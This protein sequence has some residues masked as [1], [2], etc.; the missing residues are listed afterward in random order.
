MK[1]LV[2]LA[3][4]IIPLCVVAQKETY[5]MLTLNDPAGFSREQTT[6]HLKFLKKDADRYCQIAIF[7][8]RTATGNPVEEFS[9]EWDDLVKKY[10]NVGVPD[11]KDVEGPAD[12]WTV[13]SAVA[14]AR[15]SNGDFASMLL[16]IVGHGRVTSIR[17]DVNTEAFNGDVENFISGIAPES[18]IADELMS[19]GVISQQPIVHVQA[20]NTTES[21]FK[22]QNL[23]SGVWRGLGT[24][25]T[26]SGVTNAAGTGYASF[27][28]GTELGIKQIAFFDDGTYCNILPSGGLIDYRD[29]RAKEPNYWGT[30]KL[31]NGKGSIKWDAFA[32]ADQFSIENGV[33]I[34]ARTEFRKLKSVDNWTFSGIFTAETNPSAYNGSEPTISFNSDG[35]FDDHGAIY[36][37]RHVKG[38]NEDMQDKMT[39]SGVYEVMNYTIT[40]RYDDGRL[41]RMLLF[42]P[43]VADRSKPSQLQLGGTKSYVDRK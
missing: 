15:D 4:T 33:L 10:F 38:Y 39:G 30:Y 25:A 19:K 35:R 5:D 3:L 42:D 11:K 20:T 28:T 34:Y 37:L 22:P 26:I 14:A 31:E 21:F 41:I 9:L 16:S 32:T 8:S 43:D 24:R 17:V 36:W 2:I 27:T 6:G 13:V 1:T 23:I 7:P 12:G 29:A 40:F 18:K